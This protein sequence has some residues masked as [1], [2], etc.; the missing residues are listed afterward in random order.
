MKT[1]VGT[2]K[3]LEGEYFVKDSNGNVIELH[4]GDKITQDMTVFG[5]KTNSET[6][7]IQIAMLS[8][9]QTIE[10]T[11]SQEQTFD[12][13]LVED[14]NIE[15]PLANAS[16]KDALD[17]SIYAQ[18]GA[19][20]NTDKA[21]DVIA[22]DTT[23]APDETAAGDNTKPVG[24]S[25]SDVFD[26]RDGAKVNINSTLRDASF[27]S[28][29]QTTDNQA[30][31]DQV[32]TTSVVNNEI[33]INAIS[34]TFTAIEDGH[35][36]I[37]SEDE[38]NDRQSATGNIL[39]N[40]ITNNSLARVVSVTVGGTAHALPTDGSDTTITSTYGTLTINN[41]GL[42]TFVVNETNSS[43]EALNIGNT[44]P[45][46]MQYTISDGANPSDTAGL[47]INIEGRN[48][49]PVVKSVVA[50]NTETQ[51]FHEDFEGVTK[52]TDEVNPISSDWYIDHGTNGDNILTSNANTPWVMNNAG[53]EM[54]VDGGVHG[55]HT[56]D[57]SA[58]YIEMD[59]ATPG[60]NSSITT[61]V[62]LGTNNNTFKLTFNYIPRPGSEDSS[63]MQFSLDG[64]VVNINSDASGNITYI[65]PAGVTVTIANGNN[66][67]HNITATF[68]GITSSTADLN[69]QSTG[70]A[71]TYGAYIDNI[72][73]TGVYQAT[74]GNVILS[75]V[76]NKNL[77]SATVELTNFVAGSDVI[78]L[79]N[80][81][82]D[83]GITATLT[84][85][86][87][88][89]SGTANISAYEAAIHSLTF[90]STISGAKNF[91]II[92][93]DGTKHSNTLSIGVNIDSSTH[94]IYGDLLTNKTTT[95]VDDVVN[96]GHD[97]ASGV[98]LDTAAGKDSVS[99]AH[100][101]KSGAT[102][103]T[104]TGDDTIHVGHDIIDAIVNTGTGNDTLNVDNQIQGTTQINM[105]AGDDTL[106]I[107]V[108]SNIGTGGII[109]MGAG[110][111]TLSFH[112]SL[113]LDFSN[114]N[115]AKITNLETIDLTSGDHTLS[116]LSLND[117]LHMTDTNNILT[118]RGDGNG[119]ATITAGEDNVS[120]VDTT[121]WTVHAG[122][123]VSDGTFTTYSYDSN[124]STDSITLKIEDQID[125]S[126][127]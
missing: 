120:S 72:D 122:S 107:K 84:N 14:G 4:V 3:I 20:E 41:T 104:G 48:D 77:A 125:N 109:D 100:D 67:W 24:Q 42:F 8:S 22:S 31:T 119:D 68:T 53:M 57:G 123:G 65:A 66:G 92:T 106:N 45:V 95:G 75:D 23:S 30:T 55:L 6:A 96:I 9:D 78:N 25:Q 36:Y 10:L 103:S 62:N 74:L 35:E 108:D 85:G 32:N 88:S 116:N 1:V 7:N 56:A 51:L 73:L 113:N 38:P 17:S 15:D 121:G 59:A 79:D 80:L 82:T 71:D 126:G 40:D 52:G 18:I 102:L 76:D 70:T 117:V 90:E 61:S 89:L 58:T 63:D 28:S 49:A 64:K 29:E 13:S 124:T 94:E 43:V 34:D 39:S 19:G 5:A 21:D 97:L 118:I 91:D 47:T 54:R 27:N 83:S 98:T 26:A 115:I 112:G 87:V 60:V 110:N 69:F 114:A 12:A 93:Y 105:G 16:V 11:G 37:S 111:D 2:V 101:I 50:N 44:L 81:P 127:L 86:V 46:S 33:V 99:I